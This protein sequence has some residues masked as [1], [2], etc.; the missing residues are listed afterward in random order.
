MNATLKTQNKTLFAALVS[1]AAVSLAVALPQL[2]HLVG[3]WLGVQTALGEIFLPMHLPVMLAGFFGG[4]IAGLVVGLASPLISHGLTGMPLA[5]MLPFM[6]VEL[7]G[8]GVCAGL[9]RRHK[10]PTV[11]KVLIAQ[12][13]GRGLRALA[14]VVAHYGLDVKAPPLS[15]IWTSISLGLVGIVLQ[16]VLIPLLMKGKKR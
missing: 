13:A 15:I 9:L 4:P 11:C 14:L 7:A 16:L 6:M 2:F 3:G 8:Y 1:V 12:V 10:M 5:V